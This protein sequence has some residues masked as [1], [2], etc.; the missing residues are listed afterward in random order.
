MKVIGLEQCNCKMNNSTEISVAMILCAGL[1]TRLKP[2]TDRHPKALAPVNGKSLLE[3]N[4][5]WLKSFG[6]NHLVVNVHHFANQIA[7]AIE[8]NK[9]WGSNFMISDETDAVL[10]TGGGLLKAAPLLRQHNHFVL[11]N[12]DIL[13]NL[14]IDLMIQQHLQSGA[15]AT[16]ATTGRATSRYLLF[17]PQ[18]RLGGWMNTKS[19]EQKIMRPDAKLIQQAFSGV[20]II[21]SEIFNHIRMQG[22][23]SMIDL[24]LD[25]CSSH[26]IYCFDHSNDLFIDV[27]KPESIEE[28]EQLFP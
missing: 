11:M 24:Y 16:L 12:V 1:G 28:A 18:K 9:G 2:W 14:R 6:I 10:E 15:L 19:G 8:L 13:T 25:L 26:S 4:T 21:S 22:K 17:D 5:L 20:H 3:R 23:F 27:G 7:D